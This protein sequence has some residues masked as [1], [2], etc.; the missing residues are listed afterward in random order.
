MGGARPALRR[1]A[2]ALLAAIIVVT[3]L[4]WPRFEA[5]ASAFDVLGPLTGLEQSWQIFAP[6]VRAGAEWLEVTEQHRDGATHTWR[7]EDR[8]MLMG[9][10][11][12]AR[13]RKLAERLR[14][15]HTPC[16]LS[17][18]LTRDLLLDGSDLD[19]VELTALAVRPDRDGGEVT[20]SPVLTSR[21][22][23]DGVPMHTHHRRCAT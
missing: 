23:P 16:W 18:T 19:S 13:W 9:G 14:D 20:R 11:R 17:E 3:P 4:P 21:L 1:M 6:D 8:R 2:V 7:L 12:G 15:P 5:V 10:Y 22:G